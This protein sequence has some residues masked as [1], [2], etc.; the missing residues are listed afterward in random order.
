MLIDDRDNAFNYLN[1][2]NEYELENSYTENNFNENNYLENNYNKYNTYD[3]FNNFVFNN[4]RPV[5]KLTNAE[6]GFLRGNMFNDVYDGYYKRIKKINTTNE[7][8]KSL[9]KIQE[10]TFAS[11][12]L[13]LYL[14]VY[15]ND[16]NALR[17]FKNYNKELE[18]ATKN[19]EAIYGPLKSECDKEGNEYEWIKNPWPWDK[20]GKR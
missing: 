18:K 13:G 14:D 8:E 12:D 11:L 5:S 1:E 15:P 9:L 10:L 17:V 19:Y 3:G 4:Y 20:G 6:T 16:T 7:R 2:E